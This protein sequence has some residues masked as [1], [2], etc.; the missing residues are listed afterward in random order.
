MPSLTGKELCLN[1]RIFKTPEE[2]L[3]AFEEYRAVTPTNKFLS[4]AGFF[5]YHHFSKSAFHRTYKKNPEFADAIDWI[6]TCIE[7]RAISMGADAKN[8]AFSIFFLKNACEYTDK[9]EVTNKDKSNDFGDLPDETLDEKYKEMM[10]LAE[11]ADEANNVVPI[12][13][14]G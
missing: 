5:V 6:D 9:T 14:N 4:A 1:N 12:R 13:K 2:M 10:A 3:D 11:R 8:P 7:E